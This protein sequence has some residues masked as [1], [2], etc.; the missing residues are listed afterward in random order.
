MKEELNLQCLYSVSL[1]IQQ[2]VYSFTTAANIRYNLAFVE[3]GVYFEGTSTQHDIRQ[4]YML[5]ID[6]VSPQ[7]PM[8]DPNVQQTVDCIVRHFFEDKANSLIYICDTADSRQ[9]ARKRKFDKWYNDGADN[10]EFIKIDSKI[11]T[12]D[13]VYFASVIYHVENPFAEALTTGFYEV[14]ESL[15]KSE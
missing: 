7:K 10:D 15:N 4:V 1:D 11:D 5:N 3:A 9:L 14:V 12:P 6:K 13:D 8:L 2:S